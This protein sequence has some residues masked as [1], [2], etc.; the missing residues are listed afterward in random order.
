M[1]MWDGITSI[2]PYHSQSG[3]LCKL[4]MRL[5][6]SLWM[7][8]FLYYFLFFLEKEIL[9]REDPREILYNEESKTINGR[10][11]IKKLLIIF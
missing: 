6:W 3:T 8:G 2:K 4:I 5:G 1:G 9:Q 10:T 7:I 11:V